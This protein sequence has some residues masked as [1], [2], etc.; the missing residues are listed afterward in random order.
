[1]ENISTLVYVLLTFSLSIGFFIFA[2]WRWDSARYE[3]RELRLSVEMNQI[4]TQL[5][6][7]VQRDQIL[8]AKIIQS[9]NSNNTNIRILAESQVRHTTRSVG[10]VED[11]ELGRMRLERG[12]VFLARELKE[13][14]GQ[15]KEISRNLR[16]IQIQFQDLFE[17]VR[18][19]EEEL[20]T[21]SELK[22]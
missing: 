15:N 10:W 16:S 13:T 1:M 7:L 21:P 9:V 4:R 14:N 8:T 5:I 6:K 2:I 20:K 11:I 22:N 19:L 18:K 17:A 3:R 12:I